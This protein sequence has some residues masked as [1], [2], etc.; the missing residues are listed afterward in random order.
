MR[1]GITLAALACLAVA[2]TGCPEKK[3]IV[4]KKPTR[5]IVRVIQ[6]EELYN[7]AVDA[8]RAGDQDKALDLFGKALAKLEGDPAKLMDAHYNTGV[9]LMQKGD[10]AGARKAFEKTLALKDDHRDALVNLGAI[11]KRQKKYDA[12]IKHYREA[13]AKVPRDPIIMNN[14]IVAYRLNKQYKQAEKTGHKL[15]ARAPN[16]VEAYKNMTLIYFDQGKYEM[17]ELLC[18]NAGKMLEKQRKKNPDV[19]DDAG[20]YN[21][22]GMIYLKMKQPRKALTQFNKALEVDPDSIDALINVGAIAHRYRDY[23]RAVKAYQKVLGI[24]PDNMKAQRGLAFAWYGAG[25]AK[26]SI[27]AFEKVLAENPGDTRVLFA[28]GEVYN[29]FLH[30]Y[31][32]AVAYYEKYKA[33][34]GSSL[35]SSDPVHNRLQ[36]AKAKMQMAEQIRKDEEMQRKK[37]EEE[38]KR[39]LE[40]AKKSQATEK[41]KGESEKKIQDL[42]KDDEEEQPPAAEGEQPGT[43]AEEGKEGKADTDAG[44]D[45][46][47]PG[48]EEG[49]QEPAAKEG[50][51]AK[52]DGEG[53]EEAP[54]KDSPRKNKKKT[55]DS[56][57]PA[58]AGKDVKKPE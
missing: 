55:T 41:G 45:K 56:G 22:L 25:K 8:L 31:A 34:K 54:G 35:Q 57:T 4:K 19:P 3:K 40:E 50:E 20:I 48:K 38:K 53:A 7:Q 12:A 15:L 37:E 16:N 27:A 47:Q 18:I 5:K 10:L 46:A 11:L 29:S 9:I 17:A 30:D 32:K 42:L 33:R 26:E 6:P 28:L 14:L 49:G 13:L 51:G 39:K 44:A 43:E 21:N 58:G 36:A 2:V 23:A 24:Q 1:T 52:E